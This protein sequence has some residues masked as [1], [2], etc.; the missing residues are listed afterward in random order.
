MFEGVKQF[1]NLTTEEYCFKRV[2]EL[3]ECFGEENLLLWGN[4]NINNLI[5]S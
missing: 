2:K 5:P 1:Y 3:I 4:S